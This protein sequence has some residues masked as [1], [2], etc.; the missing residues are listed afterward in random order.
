MSESILVLSH[1]IIKPIGIVKVASF[2]LDNTIIFT[3]FRYHY[4]FA[5]YGIILVDDDP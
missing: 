1:N 5:V 3:F 4:I 2:D